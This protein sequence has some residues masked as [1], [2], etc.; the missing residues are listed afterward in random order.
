MFS[1]FKGHQLDLLRDKG[2]IFFV[3]VFPT[4]LVAILGTMLNS[5]DNPDTKIEP[6]KIAYFI[7]GDDVETTATVEAII[8]EFDDVEQVEFVAGSDRSTVEDQLLKGDLSSYVVFTHPFAI[9]I[10]DGTDHLQNRAAHSIFEG[11]ARL[12]GALSVIRGAA[13]K[14]AGLTGDASVPLGNARGSE[15][16]EADVSSTQDVDVAPDES[17]SRVEEKTLGVSRSMIDYY[18]I[19]M[20]VMVL[21]MGSL[22]SS[23]SVL[24]A[25][26]KNGSLRRTLVSPHSRLSIY[27]QYTLCSVPYNLI[28]VGIVMIASSTL[29][30]AH[31]AMTWQANLLLFVMLFS[32][33]L[34]ASAVS[35]I[36]GIVIR[37]NPVA[38]TMLLAW[39]LL[40]LS[41]TFSKEIIIPGVSEYLP[42]SLIQQAAFDLTLFGQADKTIVVSLVSIAILVIATV[43][44][45][46]L[47]NRKEL[48]A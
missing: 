37:F 12:H 32:V 42:P 48:T 38:L 39:P 16:D 1:L 9:E 15:V 29:L 24:Y 27:L 8:S 17:L 43:L 25:D 13:S 18:A 11:V 31:Y 19:T 47:F 21:F 40:F 45:V 36:I 22:Q 7:E 26:R 30:G 14:G 10:H 2:T 4:L 3:V 35:L 44:G 33:G 41:G 6:M 28:Q 23:A 46:L 5:F 20:I 34:A